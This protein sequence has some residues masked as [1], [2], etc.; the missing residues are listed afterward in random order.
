MGRCRPS[1]GPRHTRQRGPAQGHRAPDRWR[2]LPLR[3]RQ[4]IL[5]RQPDRT[6]ALRRLHQD[7]GGRDRDI[8]HRGHASRQGLGCTRRVPACV[9]QRVPRV[10]RHLR[11]P[12]QLD[13]RSSR[14][15]SPILQ[16]SCAWCGVSIDRRSGSLLLLREEAGT[17]IFVIAAMHPDKV[18][19]ALGESCVCAPASPPS[20]TSPTPSSTT[21]PKRS[22]RRRSPIL[23]TSCAWCGV[24][25]DRRS[26]YHCC[27]CATVA[28]SARGQPGTPNNPAI[29]VGHLSELMHSTAASEPGHVGERR[30]WRNL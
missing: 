29:F 7:Q 2:G 26:G 13:K 17:E 5:R 8:R 4:R 10:G 23:Q 28:Q 19:D 9:L 25:I 30:V 27:F 6:L 1:R 14:R 11:L 12:Q 3:H 22:S 15:R 24:S 18:S 16:T 20:R 21:R